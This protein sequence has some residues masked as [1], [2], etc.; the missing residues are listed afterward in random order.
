MLAVHGTS[1]LTFPLSVPDEPPFIFFFFIGVKLLHNAVLVSAVQH[2]SA[3]YV[4]VSPPSS[5][6]PT[7]QSHLSRSLRAPS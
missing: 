6:S 2:E 3:I 5:T 7:P 1:A 4:H